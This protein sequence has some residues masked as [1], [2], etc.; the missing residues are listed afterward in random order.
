MY[1]GFGV[2]VWE[3]SLRFRMSGFGQRVGVRLE[4]LGFKTHALGFKP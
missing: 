4:D 1:S 2:G 3:L